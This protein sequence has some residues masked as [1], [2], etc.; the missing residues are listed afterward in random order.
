M[1]KMQKVGFISFPSIF[2]LVGLI[3]L[4]AG[5]IAQDTTLKIL[6]AAW[7]PLGIFGLLFVIH[8]LKKENKR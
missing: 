3:C 5:I 8:L 4:V 2:I 7:L 6:G 1:Q